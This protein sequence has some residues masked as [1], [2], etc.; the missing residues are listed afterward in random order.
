MHW[1][2]FRV[3]FTQKLNLGWI[4]SIWLNFSGSSRLVFKNESKWLYVY[5]S[6]L[7]Q[8]WLDFWVILTR[9]KILSDMIKIQINGW[10][11]YPLRSLNGFL[12]AKIKRTMESKLVSTM[13]YFLSIHCS[14]LQKSKMKTYNIHYQSSKNLLKSTYMLIH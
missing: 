14:Q 11:S 6:K 5:R 9:K 8:A 12:V 7:K 2:F 4:W 1:G 10:A 13:N 3:N